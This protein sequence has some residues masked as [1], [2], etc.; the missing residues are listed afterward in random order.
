[1]QRPLRV[2]GALEGVDAVDDH[3]DPGRGVL[4]GRRSQIALQCPDHAALRAWHIHLA[5]LEVLLQGA[6][7]TEQHLA[8]L[9]ALHGAAHE[10]LEEELILVQ[11]APALTYPV[12]KQCTLAAARL[13]Q[14]HQGQ[15]CVVLHRLRMAVQLQERRLVCR[16]IHEVLRAAGGEGLVFIVPR[17]L[18]ALSE[19]PHDLS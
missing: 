7:Q 8:Q 11:L 9:L 15:L 17:G 10:V 6:L 16:H 18:C 14:H 2:V 13:A 5:Q 3:G 4:L 1:M 19:R 12:G